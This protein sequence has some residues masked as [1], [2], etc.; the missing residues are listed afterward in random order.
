MKAAPQPA[1]KAAPQPAMKAAPQP[2]MKAAPQA[3]QA[4]GKARERIAVITTSYPCSPED[5][6]GHFVATEVA[7]LRAE[8]H[9]VTVVMPQSGWGR[10]RSQPEPGLTFDALGGGSAFGWPGALERMRGHPFR[11][12]GALAFITRA[13]RVV[14]DG[15]YDRLIAHWLLPA[16]W[17]IAAGAGPLRITIHGSDARVLC[18]LPR[19]LAQALLRRLLAT[20]PRLE[21]VADAPRRDLL[22]LACAQTRAT[23]GKAPVRAAPISLPTLPSRDVVRRELGLGSEFVAVVIGRLVAS[24]RV[25][26]ALECAPL[27][28]GAKIFVIGDG[29]ELVALRQRFPD[30]SFLGRLPRTLTLRWLRSADVLLTA[31]RHEGAPTVVREARALGVVVWCPPAGEAARWAICDPGICP[32]EELA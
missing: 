11:W 1:M 17:P 4:Q 23:I 28:I 9:E 24:K 19:P 25:D 7:A 5:P 2:A 18:Q 29:P 27:P 32:R 10:T 6:S 26:V 8:G 3:T 15:K 13:R 12:L 16:G 14:R 22:E 21:F 31:S 30:T 20:G